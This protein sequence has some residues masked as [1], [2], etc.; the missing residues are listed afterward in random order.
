MKTIDLSKLSQEDALKFTQVLDTIAGQEDKVR[1]E[2]EGKLLYS[3]SRPSASRPIDEYINSRP[4]DDLTPDEIYARQEK[5]DYAMRPDETVGDFLN[6]M[7]SHGPMLDE[8]FEGM[9]PEEIQYKLWEGRG[10]GDAE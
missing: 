1:I 10:Y 4:V 5:G 6:R 8:D 7:L 3:L 9:T 2:R